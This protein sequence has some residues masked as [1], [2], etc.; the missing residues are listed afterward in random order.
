M[1]AVMACCMVRRQQIMNRYYAF[2]RIYKNENLKEYIDAVRRH[3]GISSNRK[4]RITENLMKIGLIRS[5]VKKGL[6]RKQTGKPGTGLRK[7][8]D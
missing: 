6:F 2:G 1:R 8:Q 7:R 3:G 4:S 5:R